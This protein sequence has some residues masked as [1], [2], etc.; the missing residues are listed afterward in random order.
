MNHEGGETEKGVLSSVHDVH[1]VDYGKGNKEDSDTIEVKVMVLPFFLK[2]L[3][4]SD[5]KRYWLIYS[6][7]WRILLEE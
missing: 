1:S 5:S 2:H 6:I 7:V 3:A 4:F